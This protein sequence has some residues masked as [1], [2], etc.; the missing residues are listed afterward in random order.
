MNE[1]SGSVAC[2]LLVHKLIKLHNTDLKGDV[3]LISDK[4][5]SIQQDL[6]FVPASVIA[7]WQNIEQAS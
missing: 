2:L 6:G 5:F 7:F 4:L 1:G 3:L